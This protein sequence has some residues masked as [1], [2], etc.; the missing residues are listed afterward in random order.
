MQAVENTRGQ[1]LVY[2]DRICDARYSKSCGGIME[3][4]ST[5]WGG[6]DYDY[7]QVA[8]DTGPGTAEKIIPLNSEQEITE[9][10]DQTPLSFC[11]SKT[12]PEKNLK[13]YLGRVDEEG[14]YFRWQLTYSQQEICA[15]L[16]ERLN[17][18]ARSILDFIPL[19][20]GGSGRLI[21]LQIN[22][23]DR[24]GK[25]CTTLI[26]R[27][28]EIRRILHRRFLYSSCIYFSRKSGPENYPVEFTIHGAGWGHG[29]GL[30]QIGALGM[31]LQDYKTEDILKHYY[32]GSQLKLIYK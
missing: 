10:I 7:L 18:K 26:N 29:V 11:S 6:Q 21:R 5:I 28:V 13:K 20:R 30:C 12:V 2:G 23:R 4:F 8:P 24:D 14:K 25:E 22:Y 1:V 15:L 17:L 16:N 27:D 32:P 3:K 19:Q 9:W 31:A